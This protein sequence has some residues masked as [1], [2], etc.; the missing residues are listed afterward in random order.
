LNFRAARAEWILET[1]VTGSA[2]QSTPTQ[3]AASDLELAIT[4]DTSICTPSGYA[5]AI[6][7]LRRF[8]KIPPMPTPSQRV[9]WPELARGLDR[10]FGT[11]RLFG[12]GT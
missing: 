1:T 7:L 9:L 4:Q 5:H 2:L 12:R 11:P 10:F 3:H 8:D 6:S